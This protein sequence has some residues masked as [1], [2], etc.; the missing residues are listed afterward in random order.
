MVEKKTE[1]LKLSNYQGKYLL[2]FEILKHVDFTINKT[3]NS[4]WTISNVNCKEK[5]N[6][7]K[8]RSN[9]YVYK[10]TYLFKNLNSLVYWRW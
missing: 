3:I 6:Y 8:I 5:C 1:K 4:Y 7:K 9:I 10:K 2:I